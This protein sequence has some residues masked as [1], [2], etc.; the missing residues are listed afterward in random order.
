MHYPKARTDLTPEVAALLA[1]A[2]ARIGVR[3]VAYQLW[4]SEF[5]P[6]EQEQLGEDFPLG[7]LPEAYAALKRISLERAVLDLGVAADVVTLSR[8]RLLLNRLGELAA[9]QSIT[10]AVLPNFD[11]ATGILTFG[12][13][14]CAEFK[15]REPHTNRYR[16]LEAF[17][18]MD[19][20][21][22]VA[23]PLDPAKVATGIHQVVGE[24]NRKVPM[25][26]FSTQSG[27]AQICWAPAPE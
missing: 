27:G 10:I 20:A 2:L 4:E 11:L 23:N 24:L 6:A 19:W 17:Q 26:R 1:E 25:I 21:R 22:V 5:S 16:V 8:R 18:L 3:S 15:V 12:K 14:E 13:K 9:E 7:R